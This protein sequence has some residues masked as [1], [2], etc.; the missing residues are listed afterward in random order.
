MKT[1]RILILTLGALVC[2]PHA[3]KAQGLEAN[4]GADIV[5]RYIWRGQELGGVSFQPSMGI[6]A[7]GLSLSAWGNVGISNFQDT[8]ELDLTLAY[9]IG[10][11]NIGVT[12]YW[13]DSGPEPDALYFNYTAGSTNHIFE[14]NVGYD[15][16]FLAI[17]WYTNFAG[18]DAIAPN[19]KLAFSSYAELTVP[20]KIGP[21]EW[22]F[23]AGVVPFAT[24]FYAA[25]RFSL[26][27]LSLTASID[28]P[29]TDRFSL[30][31]YT[32][33]ATNPLTRQAFLLVGITLHP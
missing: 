31:V 6:S 14:A 22:S 32:T 24:E 29:I 16:G 12:D 17:Q 21:T 23:A 4:I 20:F 19:G 30:P 18:N 8:K 7:W 15:F 9:S 26:V 27:N 3:V 33:L 5:S 28:I 10:G 13:F 25:D 11:F 2:A 1:I